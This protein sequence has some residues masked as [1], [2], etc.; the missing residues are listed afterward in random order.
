MLNWMSGFDNPTANFLLCLRVH[1]SSQGMAWQLGRNAPALQL[2]SR[3]SSIVCMQVRFAQLRFYEQKALPLMLH[4]DC[5][6]AWLGA[7]ELS[8]GQ[9]CT[10]K[11]YVWRAGR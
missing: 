10:L 11:L 3:E 4:K 2:I 6:S 5:T 1:G 7:W 9:P 8:M